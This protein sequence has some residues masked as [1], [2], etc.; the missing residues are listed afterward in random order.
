MY[1]TS[2]HITVTHTT[3]VL[4]SDQSARHPAPFK[5]GTTLY[6]RPTC[7]IKLCYFSFEECSGT[8][9]HSPPPCPLARLGAALAACAQLNRLTGSQRMWSVKQ[10]ERLISSPQGGRYL[11]PAIMGGGR[12]QQVGRR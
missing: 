4:M 2:A 5:V 3:Q 9:W 1:P 10:L 6:S 12:G 8:Y 7:A 11:V